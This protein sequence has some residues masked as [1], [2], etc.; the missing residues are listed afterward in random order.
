M[1]HSWQSK[2]N[3]E[4]MGRNKEGMDEGKTIT[5]DKKQI[6]SVADPLIPCLYHHTH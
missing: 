6:T 5:N 2:D 1:Q 4:H 3:G